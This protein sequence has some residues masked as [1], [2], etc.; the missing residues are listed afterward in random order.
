M[1][2]RLK[3]LQKFIKTDA[4]ANI[5]SNGLMGDKNYLSFSPG[6]AIQKNKGDKSE[7]QWDLLRVRWMIS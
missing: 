5:G 1:L 3:N 6:D 7:L 2:A 4:M